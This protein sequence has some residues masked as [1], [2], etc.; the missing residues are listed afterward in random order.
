MRNM[1]SMYHA[2]HL[3]IKDEFP[4]FPLPLTQIQALA[5]R[6]VTIRTWQQYYGS[7]DHDYLVDTLLEVLVVLGEEQDPVLHAMLEG[8]HERQAISHAIL[9]N[10]AY[11][12]EDWLKAIEQL[13]K[14][15]MQ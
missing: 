1:A 14:A 12:T 10:P 13:I 2:V 9:F 6:V 7:F 5:Y 11:E 15:R 8:R 4:P 3:A